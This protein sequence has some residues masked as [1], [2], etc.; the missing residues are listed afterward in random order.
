MRSLLGGLRGKGEVTHQYF[1]FVIGEAKDL[2]LHQQVILCCIGLEGVIGQVQL[3]AIQDACRGVKLDGRYLI[4]F[5][6]LVVKGLAIIK[7]DPA[8]SHPV[9]ISVQEHGEV[10]AS[11]IPCEN[12]TPFDLI[13]LCDYG[14]PSC[15]NIYRGSRQLP[16]L[17]ICIGGH[18]C[19][20]LTRVISLIGH[21]CEEVIP[22]QIYS[23]EINLNTNNVTGIFSYYSFSSSS[24][25]AGLTRRE[26]PNMNR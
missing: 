23:G 14:A 22:S 18:K 6:P 25:V 15:E 5:F 26:G 20:S 24:M 8:L 21:M 1:H 9:A 17:S 10:E 19:G 12:G 4:V 7:V 2:N 13:L 3:G 16:I 11:V